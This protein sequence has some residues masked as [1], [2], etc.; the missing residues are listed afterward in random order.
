[1]V[2]EHSKPIAPPA[3]GNISNNWELVAEGGWLAGQRFTIKP[4]TLLGR[5][6]SC[7]IVIPG[8]HLSRRHAELAIQGDKLLIR[9]LGS[10]NGTF[11]NDQAITDT[12]LQAGDRIRFD[13]LVFRIQGPKLTASSASQTATTNKTSHRRKPSPAP[14]IPRPGAKHVQKNALP[15]D[16]NF[17]WTLLSV[18]TA[19]SVLAALAYL[20]THL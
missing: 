6:S 20:M 1:L 13:L 17:L 9:D 11:V 18:I 4:Y 19:V 12:E 3:S 14:N 16:S 15:T 7:D 8:T 5:D 10:A 2:G